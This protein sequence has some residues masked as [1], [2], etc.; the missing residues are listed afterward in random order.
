MKRTILLVVTILFIISANSQEKKIWAK[1]FINK[2]APS[3]IVEKWLTQ[4][5]NT[6]GKF[7]LLDFWA[8]WCGPCIKAIPELNSFQKEFK[9]DLV[10]IGISSE[11]PRK[12]KKQRN[13]KIKYFSA[14][15]RKR[16]LNTILEIKGIPHCI[17]ID[18][19]GIVRWEGY[20]I[21]KNNELTSKVIK[22]LIKKYK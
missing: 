14:I 15:D 6:E 17:L 18:P 13:P 21:L 1:S 11:T 22:E 5:P 19:R 9:K 2:K 16:R 8:T 3:I 4:K 12:V 20:P 7:I 10:V